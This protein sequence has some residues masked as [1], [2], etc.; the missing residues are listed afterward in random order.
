M[1]SSPSQQQTSIKSFIIS[2]D[3]STSKIGINYTNKKRSRLRSKQFVK[4]KR[5]EKTNH[6]KKVKISNSKTN[7]TA[8]SISNTPKKD[9][10]NSTTIL[11]SN[12]YFITP[13][14]TEGFDIN[15]LRSEMNNFN[16]SKNII[17]TITKSI[18]EN[19]T[20]SKIKSLSSSSSFL[21]NHRKSRRV[22]SLSN[23][24][25]NP[26]HIVNSNH[27]QF[28][29]ENSIHGKNRCYVED[30]L[31]LEKGCRV[32]LLI[33]R[34][35]KR[36]INRFGSLINSSNTSQLYT[37][38]NNMK[39][40]YYCLQCRLVNSPYHACAINRIIPSMNDV[41]LALS[42]RKEVCE[43]VADNDD[44]I[45]TLSLNDI[46]DGQKEGIQVWTVMKQ[47]RD[48]ANLFMRSRYDEAKMLNILHYLYEESCGDRDQTL[49]L[50][51]RYYQAL[52]KQRK[53][54]IIKLTTEVMNIKPPTTIKLVGD[55]Y[56]F[57]VD[58]VNQTFKEEII[59]C[60]TTFCS[61]T[62][63]LVSQEVMNSLVELYKQKQPEHYKFMM[64]MLGYTEK[65]NTVRSSHLRDS[66]YYD[67]LVFFQFLCQ[68]RIRNCHNLIYWGL[69][70]AGSMYG[71]GLGRS[72][73]NTSS[74]YGHSTSIQ[75]LMNNTKKWRE[76]MPEKIHLLLR[77]KDRFVCALDNNQKG[78]PLK[79]QRNG[80]SNKFVKVTGTYI[81]E[82]LDVEDYGHL[83]GDLKCDVTYTDQSIPSPYK[84]PPFETIVSENGEVDEMNMCNVLLNISPLDATIDNNSINTKGDRVNAYY[85]CCEMAEL[86]DRM[87]QYTSGLYIQSN[88]CYKFVDHCSSATLQSDN[89]K[90]VIR[91]ANS[92]KNGILSSKVT[93]HFNRRVVG[94]W[95]NRIKEV[96]KIIIPPV[97]LHD[98][99]KTDGYGMAI[100]DLLSLV[101][102]LIA[103]KDIESGKM[104]WSLSDGYQ[105]KTMYLC[106]DGL[107]LDRHR[108]FTQKLI[109]LPIRF[110]AAYEQSRIFQK[111]LNQVIEVSGPLHMKFHMLQSIFTLYENL[112]ETSQQCLQW[113]KVKKKVS[114]SYRLCESLALLC[115]EEMYRLLFYKY[116]T[117]KL[118]FEEIGCD[119]AFATE[120]TDESTTNRMMVS[121]CISFWSHVEDLANG[122]KD[123]C[124]RYVC[125]FIIIMSKFKLYL[126]A[127]LSGDYVIME[128]IENDFCGV[129][130]LLDKK[131]YVELCL[132]QME[133]RY[134]TSS[135]S[136]LQEI[137]INSPCRYQQD[138]ENE[139]NYAS[140]HVL[141]DTMENV[142]KW[143][144]ELPL[145]DTQESWI[146]HSPNVMLAQRCIK[147]EKNQNR[148]GLINFDS[149]NENSDVTM[150]VLSLS[151]YVEPRKNRER[152]R[153]YEYYM[154]L[155]YTEVEGRMF[156]MSVANDTIDLLTTTLKKQDTT[157]DTQN[158]D[159]EEC[160]NEINNICNSEENKINSCDDNIDDDEENEED[161]ANNINNLN[162]DIEAEEE[163]DDDDIMNAPNQD[164]IASQCHQYSTIDVFKA[165]REKLI[166]LN[167]IQLRRNKKERSNRHDN[168]VHNVY[169]NTISKKH[170]VKEY[171]SS[172]IDNDDDIQ[173]EL[174]VFTKMS[175][176]LSR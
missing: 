56:R 26:T 17:S 114:D 126:R 91:V 111:A 93:K 174:P 31:M 15:T 95:N 125:N 168:F 5:H 127:Q 46:M 135:Y 159:M 78:H 18:E 44:T 39:K 51:T 107:S 139:S 1:L 68:S 3:V 85:K 75:T 66:G 61:I 77:D 115:Y 152:S 175:F 148:R 34:K 92:L 84:M 25:N 169:M 41:R 164:E 142:N 10:Y 6:R 22:L 167:L 9:I 21:Q 141:D 74:F 4:G 55:D 160:I 87:R 133:K 19:I 165:G 134:N 90:N 136:Q 103:E 14:S 100:L 106:L 43:V 35:P 23:S 97:T 2:T 36:L 62:D 145:G 86:L 30:I 49:L 156:S 88:E 113:K 72:I 33:P 116:I 171:I 89:M 149:I 119:F 130:S 71:K 162:L 11:G 146:L 123:E 173:C 63:P 94:I 59:K 32:T 155:Y 58:K 8:K 144:K 60:Y 38:S 98:E 16:H 64:Q 166:K 151:R 40:Q 150:D 163:I 12:K 121:L 128:K 131:H 81:K 99:I 69:V 110:T 76:E 54:S 48:S 73:V 37:F 170:N 29:N 147:F 50:L 108:S 138:G 79:Y 158:T 132:S 47:I 104:K 153:L 161:N 118:A 109:N 105:N 27:D 20:L 112:I 122:S 70:H 124:I 172:F 7:A 24:V 129:F 82:F 140:L 176:N 120:T 101:G 57:I 154:L 45:Y 52:N 83:V 80:R 137:R 53:E 67:R 157:T 28:M 13:T 117:D 42:S 65:Q 102:I 96:S 143:V